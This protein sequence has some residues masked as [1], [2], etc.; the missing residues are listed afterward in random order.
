M[1]QLTNKRFFPFFFSTVAALSCWRDDS[2]YIFLLSSSVMSNYKW[3]QLKFCYWC[4][5]RIY[6]NP[7][8]Y[9]SHQGSCCKRYN[10][11]WHWQYFLML[12]SPNIVAINPGFYSRISPKTLLMGSV[13]AES[14]ETNHL[15][16]SLT[17]L[18]HGS[19]FWSPHPLVHIIISKIKKTPTYS[20][21]MEDVFLLSAQY[22][23][24]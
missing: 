18:I 6:S 5:R 3:K 1:D 22:F 2:Q 20:K 7:I 21:R 24:N 17:L 11:S 4:L 10:I 16:I 13:P 9:S 23:F 8:F 14:I 19:C 15:L 12:S